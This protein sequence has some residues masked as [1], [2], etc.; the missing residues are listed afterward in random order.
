MFLGAGV[1]IFIGKRTPMAT[2]LLGL[3]TLLYFLLLYVPRIIGQPHNPGPWTSGFEILAMSGA[4]VI[5]ASILPR[6][7]KE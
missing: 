4:A 5:L 7:G 2:T 6:E 3:I 1:A